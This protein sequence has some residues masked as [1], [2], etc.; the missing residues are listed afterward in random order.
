[1]EFNRSDQTCVAM[2]E[3]YPLQ[4]T[5]LADQVYEILFNGILNGEYPPGSKL[6]S[7][8]ELAERFQVSRPTIRTAF[9]RLGEL[10]YVYK[11]HGVGTFVSN[12]PDI[13]NPLYMSRDIQER[14]K[15]RGFKPG[16]KQLTAEVIPATQ[17]VS[18]RLNVQVESPILNVKKIF[19]ADDE[20]IIH[21]ENF[22]PQWIYQDRLSEKDVLAPGATEPFFQFFAKQCGHEVKYLTSIIH[23]TLLKN[24]ELP[25]ELEVCDPECPV[26]AVEDIGHNTN[27]SVIF[28]SKEHLLKDASYFYVVRHV[29]KI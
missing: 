13:T 8:N 5:P 26:L 19:T 4:N 1:M 10:G 21:F 22:I 17:Y 28:M 6:P 24:C 18:E 16:F 3:K 14:I 27:N 12:T 23:P 11:K 29:G 7:E 20:P 2:T 9:T 15:Y 25:P